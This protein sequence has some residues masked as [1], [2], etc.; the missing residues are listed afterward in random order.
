M[1]NQIPINDNMPQDLKAAINYLNEN[2]ISS[3]DTSDTD[4]SQLDEIVDETNSME[5]FSGNLNLDIDFGDDTEFLDED[6]GLEE[7][8]ANDLNSMF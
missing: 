5:D 3:S 7:Q 8:E 2:Q 1:N 4:D 6:D